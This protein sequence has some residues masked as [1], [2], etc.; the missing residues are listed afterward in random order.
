MIIDE[1]HRMDELMWKDSRVRAYVEGT[2]IHYQ[3]QHQDRGVDKAI[4]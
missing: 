2:L 4:R 1:L 3:Q